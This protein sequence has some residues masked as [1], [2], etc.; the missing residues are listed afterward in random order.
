MKRL[1]RITLLL[2]ALITTGAHRIAAQN[3]SMTFSLRSPSAAISGAAG[4]SLSERNGSAW[5]ALSNPSMGIMGF[6][7]MDCSAA[8]MLYSPSEEATSYFSVGAAYNI[9]EKYSVGAAVKYGLCKELTSYGSSGTPTGTFR[10]GQIQASINFGY[11]PLSIL[12]LG[13]NMHFLNEKLYESATYNSFAADVAI[14][15][16]VPFGIG[17]KIIATAGVY[18]LGTPVTSSSGKKFPLPGH[19]NLE[20]GYSK[21]WNQAHLLEVMAGTNWYFFGKAASVSA[22]ATYSFRSLL[23]LRCGYCYGGNSNIPSYASVG[24]GLN[25]YGVSLNVSY[26]FASEVLSNSFGISLGYSF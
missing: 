26:I 6:E 3:E 1:I 24:L 11:R 12:S 19:L 25:F 13:L 22:A 5:S 4:L 10:P 7:R 15:V 23:I 17:N 8:W 2:S 20:A 9:K 14:G 18:T 21:N 16:A